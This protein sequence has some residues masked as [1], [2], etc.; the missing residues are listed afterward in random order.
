MR[1]VPCTLLTAACLALAG[2]HSLANRSPGSATPAARA[3]ASDLRPQL[4]DRTASLTNNPPAA[5][6]APADVNGVLAGQVLDPR[7]GRPPLT[8][9]Q[10]AEA[11]ASPTSAPRETSCDSQ[12]YFTMTGLQAGKHYQLTARARSG[13]L[14]LIGTAFATPPDARIL[15]QLSDS[16]V[17][18]GPVAAVVPAPR[19]AVPG[20]DTQAVSTGGAQGVGSD[21]GWTPGQPPADPLGGAA[22][23]GAPRAYTG[24][25]SSATPAVAAPAP[26]PPVRPESV[27]T[28][29]SPNTV[30]PDRLWGL[31][32]NIPNQ[33]GHTVAPRPDLRQTPAPRPDRPAPVPS[34]ELIGQTC[35]NFA[36]R[37]LDGQPWE[38]RRHKSKLLLLDFWGTWCKY[39]VQGI[40][41]MT[42]L[43]SWYGNYGLQVVGI[44]YENDGQSFAEQ[45]RAINYVRRIKPI[46]YQLLVGAGSH[47]PVRTQFQVRDFPTVVLLDDSGRIIWRAV[48]LLSSR[49]LEDLEIIIK[50]RLGLQG[51]R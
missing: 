20:V 14:T 24:P 39:C 51:Q 28:A 34:C 7:S 8:T 44:A 6:A 18:S 29:P 50:Q 21:H 16:P 30:F 46:N 41:H 4:P 42:T 9:I 22:S 36:L 2:C 33:E 45:V 25:P 10:V 13:D 17:A 1:V 27:A 48:G 47:C 12:G 15:I 32:G 38:Y 37:D 5:S 43:Q 35:Y 40:P 26:P 23:L 19:P 31:P 3:P 11:A 49:Q